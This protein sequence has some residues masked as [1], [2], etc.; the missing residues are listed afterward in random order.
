MKRCVAT[1]AL[2]TAI[3]TVGGMAFCQDYYGYGAPGYGQQ[4]APQG[5]GQAYGQQY[6]PQQYGQA[7]GQQ[8]GQPYGQQYGQAYGQAQPGAQNYANYGGYGDY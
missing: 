8:Y 5:Y 2:V 7:Y 4:Y 1:L 3:L 6:A